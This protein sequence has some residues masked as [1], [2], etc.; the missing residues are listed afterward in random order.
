MRWRPLGKRIFSEWNPLIAAANPGNRIG[1]PGPVTQY[2]YRQRPAR[3]AIRH[4]CN[5]VAAI[6]QHADDPLHPVCSA[7]C[8]R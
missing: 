6:D 3:R 7:S 5:G 2:L 8:Y 4:M 1:R